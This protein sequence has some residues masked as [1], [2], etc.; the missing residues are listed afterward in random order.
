MVR[1]GL[2]VEGLG[3]SKCKPQSSHEKIKN[4]TKYGIRLFKIRRGRREH[5][6]L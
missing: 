1:I 4:K 3:Y 6:T 5:E 2:R